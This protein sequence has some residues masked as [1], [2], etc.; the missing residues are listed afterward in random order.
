MK[1][2]I[3]DTL[4]KSQRFVEM[5]VCPFGQQACDLGMVPGGRSSSPEMLLQVTPWRNHLY[6]G[7]PVLASGGE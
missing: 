2:L 7:G 6:A 1:H 3:K 5:P 4:A